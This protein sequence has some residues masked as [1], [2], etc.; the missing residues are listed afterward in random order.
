MELALNL[1]ADLSV[2]VGSNHCMDCIEFGWLLVML[3]SVTRQVSLLVRMPLHQ[4][5]PDIVSYDDCNARTY[6]SLEFQ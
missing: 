1:I 3:L 2:R 5:F 6:T 4:S